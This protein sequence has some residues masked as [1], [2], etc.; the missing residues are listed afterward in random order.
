LLLDFHH[1]LVELAQVDVVGV[2]ATI[3]FVEADAQV[4][5]L[6]PNLF[7]IVLAFSDYLLLTGSWA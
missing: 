7:D 1:A 5:V 6:R 3:F 4:L 2:E